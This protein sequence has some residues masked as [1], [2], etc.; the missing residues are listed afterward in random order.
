MRES[1]ARIAAD[2]GTLVVHPLLDPSTVESLARSGGWRGFGGRTATLQAL[3]GDLLPPEIL[4]RATKA[5]FDEVFWGPATRAFAHRILADGELAVPALL[6]RRGLAAAWTADP[7]P[8]VSLLLL[9][10]SWL[11]TFAPAFVKF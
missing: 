10:A 6:D 3:F 11:T 7:A 9:Q 8:A 4:A 1:L 2:A 5:H